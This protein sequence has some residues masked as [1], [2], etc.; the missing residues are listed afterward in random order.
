MEPGFELPIEVPP[1][2]SRNRMRALHQQ[3]RTAILEGRL[4]PGVKLPPTRAFAA[5]YGV[6]R[7]TAIA[8]YDLLQSEGYVSTRRGGTFV[9]AMLPRRMPA[10]RRGKDGRLS[11]YWRN[12]SPTIVTV[13]RPRLDFT[14]GVPDL[15]LFP[16]DVWKRLSAR[17]VR[18]FFRQPVAGSDSPYGRPALR[19]AIAQHVSSTRAVASS[20]E[21][22]VV[23]AGAKQAFSL[24]ARILVTPK[25][26]V[27]AVEDPG[28]RPVRIAFEAAGARIVHVPVD[29]E[30]LIVERL[31]ANARV[32]CVTP[33]HQYPL[34]VVMSASRRAQLLD[35]ARTRGAVVMEDDYDSEF[36]YGDRPLDALQTLDRSDSVFYVGTFSKSLFPGLRIGFVVAPA[37][38][39]TALAAARQ[40]ADGYSPALSQETLTAFIKEGHLVRHVRKMRRIYAARRELLLERLALDLGWL[41]PFPSAAGLH[42]ACG[43]DRGIDVDAFIA[44]AREREVG[45]GSLRRYAVSGRAQKGVMF[46]FGALSEQGIDE[47]LGRLRRL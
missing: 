25:R 19:D 43:V 33:S 14:L 30:G 11:E 40:Y 22:I 12:T 17:A 1:R 41:Q 36:R 39:R 4:K 37:W 46:G 7:N 35:F 26:T 44:K 20:V 34:G 8:T 31:P 15:P 21:D 16:L 9:T 13:E 23:T 6:S 32:I 10:E 42:L 45:L 2:R 47:A 24:L 29:Q 5:T 38:A 3:L 28:Y 27:V 18:S